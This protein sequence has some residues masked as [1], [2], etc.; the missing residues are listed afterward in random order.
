MATKYAG[1]R[2]FITDR[3]DQLKI[4]SLLNEMDKK[5]GIDRFYGK[6][7]LDPLRTV[8]NTEKLASDA[9]NLGGYTF[10][11]RKLSSLPSTFWA[12]ALGTDI[13]KEI[14]PDGNVKMSALKEILP[15]LPQ[16]LKTTLGR[17]LAAYR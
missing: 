1:V 9:L 4:A 3:S 7:I 14:A 5:A 10:S 15:T 17:Q 13:V 11:L 16:D 2:P 8:F 6:T 12:D